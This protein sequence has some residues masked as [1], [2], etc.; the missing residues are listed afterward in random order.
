MDKSEV[1]KEI[2]DFLKFNADDIMGLTQI[3]PDLLNAFNNVVSAI[4]EQYGV[5]SLMAINNVVNPPQAPK[6][7]YVKNFTTNFVIG[8]YLNDVNAI[9]VPFK[10]LS[11]D[12][13]I[14][15]I[16][17]QI[18]GN[19]SGF[20]DTLIIKDIYEIEGKIY[21]A[22]IYQKDINFFEDLIINQNYNVFLF[23]VDALDSHYV[24]YFSNAGR[25]KFSI[26]SYILCPSLSLTKKKDLF[27]SKPNIQHY[28]YFLSD[29]GMLKVENLNGNVE[30]FDNSIV[31]PYS[32]YIRSQVMIIKDV[33]NVNGKNYYIIDYNFVGKSVYEASEFDDCFGKL[34]SIKNNDVFKNIGNYG[35]DVKYYYWFQ[36]IDFGNG[37]LYNRMTKFDSNMSIIDN[38][39]ESDDVTE[40]Y[41]EY[42][43]N[44]DIQKLT[45]IQCRE[46]IAGYEK[47]NPMITKIL[48]ANQ[49]GVSSISERPTYMSRAIDNDGTR[50][51]PTT[52]AT[53]FELGNV[54]VGSDGFLWEISEDKNGKKRW[55][56]MKDLI[57]K[58]PIDVLNSLPTDLFPNDT[59]D[60]LYRFPLSILQKTE[61][62]L[63]ENLGYFDKNTEDYTDVKKYLDA[64]KVYLKYYPN[65]D[66]NS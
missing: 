19:F 12:G 9:Y 31:N 14:S 66:L 8:D 47:N 61:E 44:G 20:E 5:G 33:Q 23:E 65:I 42:F 50:K 3:S 64:V 53:L 45:K 25:T 13:L 34:S 48:G 49:S 1:S 6:P 15:D 30:L 46:F 32:I 43:E 16:E 26:G 55:Q 29:E 2:A 63:E 38:L 62:S 22:T 24:E 35:I 21:Y 52:S 37:Y 10:I 11:S 4:D 41:N 40:F 27:D 54:M 51:S 57:K 59:P 18:G 36:K 28:K 17:Y 58:Q 56:V 7:T 39:N 60:E